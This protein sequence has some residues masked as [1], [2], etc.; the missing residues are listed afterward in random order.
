MSVLQSARLTELAVT[1]GVNLLLALAVLLVGLWLSGW[2][3][4]R[5]DAYMQRLNVDVTLRS[6]LRSLMSLALKVLVIITVASMLGV[7]TTSFIAVLGAAGLA[8]GLALQGSLSNFAGGVLLIVFKPY[9]VGDFVEMQGQSGT[10]QSIQILYTVLK[11]PDNKTVFVP[12]GPVANSNIVNF[13]TEATRRVDMVF[14]ISY[15][16]SI[17]LARQTLDA[18]VRADG[19]VL[20]VPAPVI[21]VGELADSAVNFRVRVWTATGDYWPVY[22]DMQER[23]KKRFDEVGLSI[24]F[25]QRDVHLRTVAT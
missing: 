11:T 12:N 2:L 7:A 19:R 9:R 13:S 23:V 1:Y 15:G 18:L 21:V 22:F 14:S 17:D 4:R 16:S 3:G 24:P 8:V 5:L 25:P 10:V 20:Q 6:F